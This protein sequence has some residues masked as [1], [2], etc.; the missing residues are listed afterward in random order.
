[1]IDKAKEYR[2][3]NAIKRLLEKLSATEEKQRDPGI[4]KKRNA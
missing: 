1:M 2:K 3:N 4:E